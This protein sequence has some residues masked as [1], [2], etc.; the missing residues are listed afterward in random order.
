MIK[1]N[2]LQNRNRPTDLEKEFI[3]TRGEGWW[4]GEGQIR[5]W[6]RAGKHC[7]VQNR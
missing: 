5:R 7:Y 1:M 6:R 2:C 3:V 4:R